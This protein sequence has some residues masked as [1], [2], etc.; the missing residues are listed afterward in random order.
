M[1]K[2]AVPPKS[3]PVKGDTATPSMHP[4]FGAK[5]ILT[6]YVDEANLGKQSRISS[7]AFMPNSG[8]QY[9]SVNSLE[10]ESLGQIADY[11]RTRISSR[12]GEVAVSCLTVMEYN[13]A[14]EAGGVTI[15]YNKSEGRWTFKR[16]GATAPTY[17][18]RPTHISKSHAG[19][20]PVCMM[21]SLSAHKF[22]R[23]LA[24]RPPGKNPH[25]E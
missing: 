23:N 12:P 22:A 9:L 11:Y 6:R 13:R 3:I 7:S 8:E 15:V 19:V 17:R 20:E 4:T 1:A 10:I 2:R 16:D 25:W 21:D 5:K 14:C 24:G 18:F